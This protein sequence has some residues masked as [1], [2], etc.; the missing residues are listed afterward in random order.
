[1]KATLS[2]VA[3]T[4]KKFGPAM[5]VYPE[6]KLSVSFTCKLKKIYDYKC[7]L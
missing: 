1:L 7:F 2:V 3:V 4:L 6:P 5:L